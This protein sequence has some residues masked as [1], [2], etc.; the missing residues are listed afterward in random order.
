MSSI[1]ETI[2]ESTRHRV[3]AAKKAVDTAGLISEALARRYAAQPHAFRSSIEGD[4]PLSVIA[5]FKKA[6]PSRGLINAEADPAE[7]ALAYEAGGA[8][9]VS[10]LT[11]P[12]YFHGSLD[13]LRA[14][15]R[16]VSIPILRKDFIVDEFQIYEAAEAGA[17][18]IL[19][20]VAALSAEKL[21][22]LRL[23][24]ED[25]LG[26]DALVE[27]HTADE[28]ATA[29]EIDA[30]L[31]GVNNR[32]L[33]TFDISLDVSRNLVR[34]APASAVLISESGIKTRDEIIELR[35]LGYSGFLIGETLMRDR[36]AIFGEEISL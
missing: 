6:S 13:D 1:L 5:E 18:A 14:I 25:E 16:A 2:L 17:D 24:T 20:I 36:A 15:R 33:R 10:V 8:A 21:Q 27:V 32:D 28:M 4:E 9:A 7:T 31:I 3:A 12:D 26:M 30:K 23:L 22:Q 19:L 11:E 35:D 34:L 29:V